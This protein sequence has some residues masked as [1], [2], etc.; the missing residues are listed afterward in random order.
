MAVL[1]VNVTYIFHIYSK[2]IKLSTIVAKKVTYLVLWICTCTWI[3]A[4][5][6][7][8]VLNWSHSFILPLNYIFFISCMRFTSS[9][10]SMQFHWHMTMH[11][12]SMLYLAAHL[13][14]N[15]PG[16]INCQLEPWGW[17]QFTGTIIQIN[18]MFNLNAHDLA[19]EISSSMKIWIHNIWRPEVNMSLPSNE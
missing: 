5:R 7:G 1:A 15:E 10:E 12:D 14:A 19:V 4:N 6:K 9:C 2:Q 17:W 16:T 11:V 13:C 8:T 3:H 18:Q